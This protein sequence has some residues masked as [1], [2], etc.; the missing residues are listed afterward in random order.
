MERMT[1]AEPPTPTGRTVHFFGFTQICDLHAR[2]IAWLG[3]GFDV[4]F[5]HLNVLP[6]GLSRGSTDKPPC[7]ISRGCW[8]NCT[9]NWT[10]ASG[11]GEWWRTGPKPARSARAV[12]AIDGERIH[13][14]DSLLSPSS[15]GR[16]RNRALPASPSIARQTDAEDA[17][18]A[19]CFAADR[20]LSRRDRA[21]RRPFLTAS[22]PTCRLIRASS[23][24]TSPCW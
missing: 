21:R 10:L 15:Q 12:D 17:V 1:A 24:T 5:Y 22:L 14:R 19:G 9:P 6:A 13:G 3:R 16:G 20:R 18:A 4:R 2:T 8:A 7:S 11:C 23:K